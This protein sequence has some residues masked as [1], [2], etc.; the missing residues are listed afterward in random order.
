MEDKNSFVLYT[1]YYEIIKDATDED[2]GL[3]FKAILE[4]TAT[5]KI[6]ELPNNLT[7]A[8]KNPVFYV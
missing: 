1:N 2:A 5:G 4:Y 6:S 8:L 7:L 3:L